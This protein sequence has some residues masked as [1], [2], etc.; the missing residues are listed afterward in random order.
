MSGLRR[1]GRAW[2]WLGLIAA[3]VLALHPMQADAADGPA[4]PQ[5][6][7]APGEPA[8]LPAFE[9]PDSDGNLVRA[10]DL[11]GKVVVARFWATW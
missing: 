3:T 7:Q 6:M 10:A 11:Q 8:S 5:G 1:A 9:L 4:L 2:F